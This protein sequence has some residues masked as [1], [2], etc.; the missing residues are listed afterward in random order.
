[1]KGETLTYYEAQRLTKNGKLIDV[2]ASYRPITSASGKLLFIVGMYKDV[3]CQKETQ[4]QLIESEQKYRFIKENT[5]DLI[6]VL[7]EAGNILYLSPSVQNMLEYP[8]VEA[9]LGICLLDYIHNED[10]EGFQN[11]LNEL[12]DDQSSHHG[13]YRYLTSYNSYKWC[14]VKGTAVIDNGVLKYIFV[15][16]DS[17]DQKAV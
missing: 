13:E 16:R 17:S 14:D 5:T 11:M 10:K 1:M 15:S 9:L 12:K 6:Q 3:T 8:S 4:R 2:V 7:D